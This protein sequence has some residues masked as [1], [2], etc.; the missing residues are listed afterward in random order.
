M[1]RHSFL[2]AFRR[3][4]DHID[5]RAFRPAVWSPGSSL[6]EQQID[7]FNRDGALVFANFYTGDEFERIHTEVERLLSADSTRPERQGQLAAGRVKEPHED[8]E[9]LAALPLGEM[10]SVIRVLHGDV[11]LKQSFILQKQPGAERIKPWHQDGVYWNGMPTI[12]G[13]VSVTDIE[14]ERGCLWVIPGSHRLGRLFHHVERDADG[15]PNLVCDVTAMRPPLPIETRRGDLVLLH[16]L[17]VHASF[18]N[19]T[20]H[21]RSTLGYHYEPQAEAG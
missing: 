16:G 21:P 7:R 9:L 19:K 1:A 3:I 13:L 5:R 12:L 2:D 14:Q 18:E 17:S 4:D 11:A 10:K 8:S 15:W 20:S 6:S